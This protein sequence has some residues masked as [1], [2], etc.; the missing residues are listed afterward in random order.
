M[1]EDSTEYIGL[2]SAEL[3]IQRMIEISWQEDW[4]NLPD[5]AEDHVEAAYEHLVKA[6]D[7]AEQS[8]KQEEDQ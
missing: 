1:T 4:S 2:A 8:R 6:R 5:N 3:S 7:I